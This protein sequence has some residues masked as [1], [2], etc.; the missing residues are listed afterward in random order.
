M[1][2]KTRKAMRD[3]SNRTGKSSFDMKKG[4]SAVEAGKRWAVKVVN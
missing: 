4:E 3:F 1:Y 2:F